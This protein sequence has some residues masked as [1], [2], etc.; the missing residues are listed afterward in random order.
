MNDVPTLAPQIQSILIRDDI[1]TY[2]FF[3]KNFVKEKK[4]NYKV[5]DYKNMDSIYDRIVKIFSI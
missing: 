5:N 4:K 1:K 2:Y 3:V